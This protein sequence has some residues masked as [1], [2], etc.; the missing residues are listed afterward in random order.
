MSD[1]TTPTVT[2]PRT[3][4]APEGSVPLP[5]LNGV[6]VVW[7]SMPVRMSLASLNAFTAACSATRP[8]S[9][10]RL[11]VSDAPPSDAAEPRRRRSG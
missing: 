9:A 1:P 10:R 2:A 6:R 8:T 4:I 7:R 3:L 5:P 11:A